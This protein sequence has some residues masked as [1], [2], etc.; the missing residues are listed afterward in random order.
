MGDDELEDFRKQCERNLTRSVADR[1][2]Y[3]FNYTYKPVLDDA[4]WR[5]FNSMRD[6][7]EWCQ[8]NLP[9][10][11]GYGSLLSDESRMSDET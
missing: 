3:G 11:L 9:P 5:S 8:K 6:Y 2:R 10:Y 4:A 1:M 7:R